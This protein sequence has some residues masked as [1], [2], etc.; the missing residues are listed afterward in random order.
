MYEHTKK[1]VWGVAGVHFNVLYTVLFLWSIKTFKLKAEIE[2]GSKPKNLRQLLMF[3]LLIDSHSTVQ[4]FMEPFE[5]M[6]LIIVFFCWLH[7]LS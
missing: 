4:A 3:V 5:K 6:H 2:C 1:G 7:Q